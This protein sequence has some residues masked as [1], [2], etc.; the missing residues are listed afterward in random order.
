MID[1]STLS[2]QTY[3]QSIMV[4]TSPCLVPEMSLDVRVFHDPHS[5]LSQRGNSS[6]LHLPPYVFVFSFVLLKR[7]NI[8]EGISSSALF[9]LCHLPRRE[10]Q[11][12][13]ASLLLEEKRSYT[14]KCGAKKKK[15]KRFSTFSVKSD[16]VKLPPL[17]SE[18]FIDQQF[19]VSPT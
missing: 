8:L 5:F 15:K 16:H 3:C 9:S 12:A 14:W 11:I 7:I 10:T 13:S 1:V 2:D 19:P 4:N 18:P 6:L 17:S